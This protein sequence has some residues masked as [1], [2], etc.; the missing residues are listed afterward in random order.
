[1]EKRQADEK[2]AK[3]AND[4]AAAEQK[5]FVDNY[6]KACNEFEKTTPDFKVAYD[7]LLNSRAAELRAIGYETPETLHQAL[8]AD[9]FAIAQM[10]FERGKSPAELIYSLANQ[11]GYKKAAAANPSGDAEKA[12]A[13][14]LATI[15]R[16]QAAHKSLS[17]TGG[18][19]GDQ[20]MTA[21]ALIA[22][23][24]EEFEAWC[25]KNPAKA[26]R[27]FGG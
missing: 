14:K 19:S 16:G 11:R 15:E 20:E 6:T 27:I 5:T 22:M 17:N 10:A 12:A 4:K 9:E 7:F 18:S 3:E 24:A 2:A 8:I 13:E 26:R 1:M 23:P 25:E 21:E